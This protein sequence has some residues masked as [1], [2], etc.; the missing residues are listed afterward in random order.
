VQAAVIFA[1]VNGYFDS[2]A[3]DEVSKTEK[4]LRDYLA[5]E[6]GDVLAAIREK[7]EIGEDTEKTLREILAQFVERQKA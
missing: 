3:P 4:K 6:G 1:A 5:R 2:F 7:K